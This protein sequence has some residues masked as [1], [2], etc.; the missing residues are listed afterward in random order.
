[1]WHPDIQ[2]GLDVL[3]LESPADAESAALAL[4]WLVNRDGPEAL[5]RGRLQDFLYDILPGQLHESLD[6]QFAIADALARFLDELR[7]SKYAGMCRTPE[8]RTLL[9]LWDRDPIRGRRY[10]ERLRDPW[11]R[12]LPDPDGLEWG[13]SPAYWEEQ[14]R[15]GVSAILEMAI[16]AGEVTPGARGW[17]R[18]ASELAAVWMHTPNRTFR[19]WTPLDSLV[20]ERIERWVG[21]SDARGDLLEPLI[22]E[23]KEPVPPPENVSD[24]VEPA[25][26]LLLEIS[27]GLYARRGWLPA[28]VVTRWARSQ[29]FWTSD[30]DPEDEEDVPEL[31]WLRQLLSEVRAIR[32]EL[33]HLRVTA[34]GAAWLKDD[35]EL[36]RQLCRGLT[37]E[38]G[39]LHGAV[40]AAGLAALYRADAPLTLDQLAAQ[41][42]SVLLEDGWHKGYG[43]AGHLVPYGSDDLRAR[44]GSL[45]DR[46]AGVRALEGPATGDGPFRLTAAGR[47]T[48]LQTL[49][50]AALAPR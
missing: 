41:I 22:E 8:F 37:L 20:I 1:M 10:A 25:R 50:S 2:R 15:R 21:T 48:A 14:A 4:W 5:T 7:L 23:L 49:R 40:M 30:E 28:A 11:L 18:Q 3:E 13:G 26:A 44:I 35:A 45:R 6:E 34:K 43:T 16:E 32:E 39:R 36:W 9:R 31:N 24:V 17:K 12:E 47:R 46:L 19:G 29:G 38:P 33:S 27:D 42:A